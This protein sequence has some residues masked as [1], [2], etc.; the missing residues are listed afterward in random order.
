MQ[1]ANI[2]TKTNVIFFF[3][4]VVIAS[5]IYSPFVLTIGMIGLI[6]TALVRFDWTKRFPL[7]IDWAAIRQ[8]RHFHR[9]PAFWAVT[10]FFFL[11]VFSFS[12]EQEMNFWLERLR[13]KMPFIFLPLTFFIFPRFTERQ[14]DGLWY[15]M[16][17]ALSITAIAIIFNFFLHQEVIIEQMKQ[18][19]PMP[20]PRNHIRF[21]LL[22]VLGIL[23]GLQLSLKGYYWRKVWERKLIIGLTIFLFGFI[24]FLSVRTGILCLYAALAVLTLYYAFMPFGGR[25]RKKRYLLGLVML[26][27]LAALPLLAYRYVPSVK[28]KIDYMIW[29][30]QQFQQGKG[31]LTADAG[32]IHSLIIG[33]EIFKEH[34]ITGVGMG[35]LRQEVHSRFEDQYPDSNEKHMPHNQFLYVMAGSGLIGLAVFL[36]GILVPFFYQQNY[37]RPFFLGFYV[38]MMVAFMLEHT[39]ENSLGV[40]LFVFF[41]LVLLNHTPKT[42]PT[43]LI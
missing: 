36:V 13:I 38:V 2:F 42:S 27:G 11:V 32:R 40:A 28:A 24:H 25:V 6:A 33:Y 21:S 23:A 16:L 12:P 31:N 14:L 34:P 4:W 18:G 30:L 37:Q 1:A 43:K 26:L 20:T 3:C 35:N 29:D 17:V 41:L 39:I 9:A 10:L 7:D 15:F 19:K 8:L 5:I 22:C